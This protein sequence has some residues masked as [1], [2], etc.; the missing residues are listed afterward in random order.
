MLLAG[1]ALGLDGGETRST[2]LARQIGDAVAEGS[3]LP[4]TYHD[5]RFSS[6]EAERRLIE[7][8]VSR[9]ARKKR[10]D[11]SAAAVI[12]QDFLES[13]GSAGFPPVTD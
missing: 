4:V 3:D 6:V 12:L 8:D 10:I 11:Q 5:E 1:A 2:R 13:V 9:K 7:R